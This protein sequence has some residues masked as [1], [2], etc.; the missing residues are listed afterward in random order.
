[1]FDLINKLGDVKKKMDEIRQRLDNVY[2]D[3]EAGSGSVKVTATGNRKIKS[4]YISPD[5]IKDT[6]VD[7]LQGLI[8]VAVNRALEK[9]EAVSE[10]EMK[11]AGKD[12]LPGFPGF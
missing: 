11:S 5:L 7:Q 8:E 4:I 12:F 9:A 1:M 2:V 10:S 6:D 3:G